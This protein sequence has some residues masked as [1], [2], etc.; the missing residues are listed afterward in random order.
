MG[1]ELVLCRGN[2]IVGTTLIHGT[3]TVV[4]ADNPASCRLSNNYASD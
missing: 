1:H 2:T 4:S 3:I